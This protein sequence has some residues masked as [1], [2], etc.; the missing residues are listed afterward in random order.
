MDS[1]TII[2]T[3]CVVCNNDLTVGEK[4]KDVDRLRDED[5]RYLNFCNKCY[6]K[7][8]KSDKQK[9]NK[10]LLWEKNTVFKIVKNFFK[11]F[12]FLLLVE[13]SLLSG[14]EIRL[15]LFPMEKIYHPTITYLVEELLP[16]LLVTCP[17]IG[18]SIFIFCGDF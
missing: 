4:A 2:A 5:N 13:C 12:I 3:Q 10:Y 9:W 11:L 18:V 14:R 1:T 8:Y 6:L 15:W 16:A 17:I 7:R